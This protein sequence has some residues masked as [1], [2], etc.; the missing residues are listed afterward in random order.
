M[1]RRGFLQRLGALVGG[2]ALEQAIPFNRVWSFPSQIVIPK[3][4]GSGN[5]FLTVEW[6]T[7][8]TLQILKNNLKFSETSWSEFHS[9]TTLNIR[10]PARYLTPYGLDEAGM[11]TGDLNA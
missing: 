8:E 4:Y 9:G 3:P 6:I 11:Y 1:N 10:K 5:T 7:K 2:V